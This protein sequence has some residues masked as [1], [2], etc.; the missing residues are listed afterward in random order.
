MIS[1][2]GDTMRRMRGFTL[3]ELLVVVAILAILA[4]VAVPAYGRYSFRARRADGQELLLRIANAQERF[5]ATNNKYGTLDDIGFKD[6]T[7][8]SEHGFYTATIDD[9]VDQTF[10][11]N[12]VPQ[13]SQAGDACDNL[14][15]SNTGAK[16][17]D[18]TETNGK[19]W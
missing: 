16:T 18:G 12:A 2:R 9:G 17:Q 6:T 13:L 1:K 14:H 11:A 8:T 7:V 5:Y 19:C 15:I 10:T 4:A 3:I